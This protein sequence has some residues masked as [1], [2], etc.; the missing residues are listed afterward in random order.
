MRIIFYSGMTT[1]TA[2]NNGNESH[3]YREAADRIWDLAKEY[4]SRGLPDLAEVLTDIAS[5]V[6]VLA[7]TK[8]FTEMTEDK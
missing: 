1:D 3:C 7:R 6:H 8:E 5:E 2:K 4:E